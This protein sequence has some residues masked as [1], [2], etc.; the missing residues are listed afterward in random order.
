M[1]SWELSF[2][3]YTPHPIISQDKIQKVATFIYY[4][5]SL[6]A[7]K[8]TN[9]VSIK[10][11][12]RISLAITEACKYHNVCL[13]MR[14]TYW[15]SKNILHS[16]F[17]WPWVKN[18][19]LS[20]SKMRQIMSYGWIMH[21]HGLDTKSMS[22]SPICFN[23]LSSQGEWLNFSFEFQ[24]EKVKGSS[25]LPKRKQQK[26]RAMVCRHQAKNPSCQVTATKTCIFFF[27]CGLWFHI[28]NTR[29]PVDGSL[30]CCIIHT[31]YGI[32]FFA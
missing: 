16:Y 13:I 32:R 24:T 6:L 4:K 20:G 23:E 9:H 27:L 25:P 22:W 18:Q 29:S 3:Y 11:Q 19:A 17:S 15:F 1:H 7:A 21:I 28:V 8:L 31:M 12:F 26:R 2:W 10:L 14:L 30:F 5:E